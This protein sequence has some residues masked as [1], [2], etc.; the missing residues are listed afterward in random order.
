MELIEHLK[1]IFEGKIRILTRAV[2][3]HGTSGAVYLPKE[4]VNKKV[5]ILV[6][7]ESVITA[8]EENNN[9]NQNGNTPG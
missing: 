5:E 7:D 4:L 9:E 1:Q 8:A 6:L 2:K 3:N